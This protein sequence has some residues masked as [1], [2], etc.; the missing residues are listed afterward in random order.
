M[1]SH[2]FALPAARTAK[3]SAARDKLI[4]AVSALLR[5][6]HPSELTTSMI[7]KAA[8]V[9]RNTLY[10]HFEDL[11]NLLEIVLLKKFSQ[12]VEAN[13]RAARQVVENT[14]S[15]TDF[16]TNLSLL[17]AQTQ[18]SQKRTTRFARCRLVAYSESNPR[19]AKLFSAEQERLNLEF[20]KVF[21]ILERRGWVRD[22]V[23]PRAAGVLVQALTLGKVIDDVSDQ[24]MPDAQW[25]D[26]FLSI[27]MKTLIKPE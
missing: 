9:A 15:K 16:L 12:S 19:L 22:H 13:I 1:K 8:N 2:A 23:D 10:L 17:V 25:N 14:T 3:P 11:S 24:S 4:E 27:V 21:E 5:D 26:M 7:L 6:H 18:S 20:Q